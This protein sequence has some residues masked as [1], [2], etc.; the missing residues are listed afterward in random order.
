MNISF[1]ETDFYVMLASNE[2]QENFKDNTLAYFK[3]QLPTSLHL[4]DEWSVGITEIYLPAFELVKVT[5]NQSSS[6]VSNPTTS[7]PS[8]KKKRKRR[9]FSQI[10]GTFSKKNR[11]ETKILKFDN[12]L[13]P[14]RDKTKDIRIKN[15]DQSGKFEIIIPNNRWKKLEYHRNNINLGKILEILDKFVFLKDDATGDYIQKEYLNEKQKNQLKNVLENLKDAIMSFFDDENKLNSI[16]FIEK[17]KSADLSTVHCYLGSAKSINIQISQKTY[18][19]PN[20]F[21]TEIISQ[22]LVKKRWPS[23]WKDYFTKFYSPYV[24]KVPL[25]EFQKQKQNWDPVPNTINKFRIN[26]TEHDAV[27]RLPDKIIDVWKGK[28]SIPFEDMLQTFS[29]NT[30]FK[31]DETLSAEDRLARQN[32]I[33]LNVIES[34]LEN[35]LQQPYIKKEKSPNSNDFTIEIP[36]EEETV[37]NTTTIKILKGVI[38]AETYDQASKFVNNII[39]QIPIEQRNAEFFKKMFENTINNIKR[40]EELEKSQ[41]EILRM[42]I[43]N[44][45]T[46]GN[47]DLYKRL[48]MS[49]SFRNSPVSAPAS[50]LD[51]LH[52]QQFENRLNQNPNEIEANMIIKRDSNQATSSSSSTALSASAKQLLFVH[53]S[54]IRGHIFGSRTVKILRSI[55]INEQVVN[56]YGLYTV[57]TSPHYYPLEKNYFNTIDILLADRFGNPLKFKE[58]VNPVY[59]MLH[60][61]RV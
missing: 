12:L 8:D 40:K 60:F 34:L 21:L 54:I 46:K 55:P 27:I 14:T 26:I 59:L 31:D 47:H 33:T 6:S 10:F 7:V 11:R 16:P 5:S 20:E 3:N 52:V 53:T 43:A 36:F 37:G 38:V 28:D 2:S 61:K 24:S 56:S 13:S 1:H 58:N 23:R 18:E 9:Q 29:K 17:K 19:T 32:L 50:G 25:T 44:E 45:I 48:N 51:S 39:E 42:Q 35:N 15:I 30:H 22:I 4:D 49:N 41:N 57:Y